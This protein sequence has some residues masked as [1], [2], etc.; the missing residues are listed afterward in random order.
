[1]RSSV[2]SSGCLV[3]SFALLL[4]ACG[5]SAAP[6]SSSTSAPAATKPSASPSAPA[7]ATNA[8]AAAKPSTAGASGAAAAKPSTAAG[9]ASAAAKPSAAG[10][11]TAVQIGYAQV[12]DVHAPVFVAQEMGFF[13]QNG[14]AADIKMVTGP[15][16]AASIISGELQYGSIGGNE[17]IHA[18]LGGGP[19]VG[20]ATL[21]DVPV[22]SLYADKKYKAVTDLDGQTIA[23]TSLGTTTE[24]TAM[25]ILKH[26]GMLGK[27]KISAA[28]GTN[29]GV[30]AGLMNHQFAGAIVNPEAAQQLSEAGFVELANAVKLGEPFNFDVL[31]VNRA[32]LKDH[33]D[34]ARRFLRAYQQAWTYLGDPANKA[35]VIKIL[36][37]YTKSDDRLAAIGYDGFYPVW[38]S[39]KVPTIDPRAMASVLAFST[40]PAAKNAK[41]EQFIDNSIIQS[42]QS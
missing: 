30:L 29:T 28:G 2:P 18:D 31:A 41:P 32:Y 22:F 37:K 15:A 40:E 34:D 12:S 13:A 36:Q 1:M 14:I 25:L 21:A 19:L 38:A 20:I 6:A 24:A 26:F 27:V 35:N 7:A 5:G 8:A 39:Q 17:V 3:V 16:I 10:A 4:A 33:A 23:V 42:I 11:G 9:S